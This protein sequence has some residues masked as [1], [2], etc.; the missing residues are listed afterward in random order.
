VKGDGF[1]IDAVIIAADDGFRIVRQTQGD[2]VTYVVE[3]PKGFDALGC[4]RWEDVSAEGKVVKAMRDFIIRAAV[5]G[6]ASAK[7]Q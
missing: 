1:A 2:K 4:E 7:N 6:E 5:K 3:I